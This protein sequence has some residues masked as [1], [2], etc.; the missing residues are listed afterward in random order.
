MV[1]MSVEPKAALWVFR[2]VTQTAAWMVYNGAADSDDLWVDP[3][4]PLRVY[5]LAGWMVDQSVVLSAPSMETLS[6]DRMVVW[7]AEQMAALMAD[8]SVD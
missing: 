4:A 6:V 7:M 8:N 1:L 5:L 2:W 3:R